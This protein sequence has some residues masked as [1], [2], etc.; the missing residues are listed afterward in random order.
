MPASHA[1][2][3]PFADEP[4]TI[5]LVLP[6]NSGCVACGVCCTSDAPDASVVA[7]SVT[8]P[9]RITCPECQI[10]WEETRM[11][12]CCVRETD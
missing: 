12:P 2:F 11:P 9:E 4:C 8:R 3:T 1:I 5:H 7:T 10:I 6:L